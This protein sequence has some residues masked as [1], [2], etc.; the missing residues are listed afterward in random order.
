[1]PL[2]LQKCVPCI[3]EPR[4]SY[5]H[6]RSVSD[7]DPSAKLSCMSAPVQDGSWFCGLSGLGRLRSLRVVRSDSLACSPH[8][9]APPTIAPAARSQPRTEHGGR[10]GF[11]VNDPGSGASIAPCF[12]LACTDSPRSGEPAHSM[13]RARVK[14][15]IVRPP[16]VH[17]GETTGGLLII[18]ARFTA[19]MASEPHKTCTFVAAVSLGGY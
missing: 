3:C 11:S 9:K 15:D 5:R 16:T 19:A 4:F 12:R 8:S 7:A 2:R 1:M 13:S 14:Q 18:Y 17:W 6:L 10:T